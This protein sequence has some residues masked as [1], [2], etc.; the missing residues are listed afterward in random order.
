MDEPRRGGVKVGAPSRASR[1]RTRWC[2]LSDFRLR[3]SADEGLQLSRESR[4]GGARCAVRCNARFV[5]YAENIDVFEHGIVV[6]DGERP[7]AGLSIIATTRQPIYNCYS[8]TLVDRDGTSLSDRAVHALEVS[9]PHA[10][11]D[12]H[13]E[14]D[15]RFF[16][17]ESLY[18][19]CWPSV[20][21][22]MSTS[23][24]L[25]TMY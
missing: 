14:S 18:H 11:V 23:L 7:P 15:V 13:E 5:S 10:V 25:M 4:K 22:T 9:G 24:A 20:K 12:Y 19:L 21:M 1:L 8:L 16:L 17:R 2:R 3:P 6:S